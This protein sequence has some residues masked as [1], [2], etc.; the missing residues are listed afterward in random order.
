M[1]GGAAKGLSMSSAFFLLVLG[2]LA[3]RLALE[4]D[5]DAGAS[6]RW[7]LLEQV[8]GQLAHDS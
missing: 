6:S 8:D 3:L 7:R 2:F 4:A 1:V 5:A